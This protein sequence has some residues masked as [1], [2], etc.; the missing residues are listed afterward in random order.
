MKT[1]AVMGIC[2]EAVNDIKL[3]MEIISAKNIVGLDFIM[4]KMF[5][6]NVV[7][8]RSGTGKVNA[9][10]C[11]QI[12]ID[13]YAV[14]YI[15]NL[16]IAGIINPELNTGDIV[17]SDDVCYYDFDMSCFGTPKGVIYRMD[18]SFFKAD[19]DLIAFSLKASD[20]CGKN[21]V[22]GRI[23][24]GD[25]FVI[26][27]SEKNNIK[28]EFKAFC[29][30][31]E[32]GAVAHTCYLNKIPFVI[33]SIVFNEFSKTVSDMFS[34]SDISSFTDIIKKMIDMTD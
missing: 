19:S 32:S 10:I 15:I 6:N 17:I 28:N 26:D 25:K 24:T 29:I 13:M 12:L 8:V 22:I 30:D 14:D 4:G 7:L 2:E 20:D 34:N 18:E 9:S 11:T 31:M 3:E 27:V 23:A 16:S 5:G 33:V 1:I 21:A